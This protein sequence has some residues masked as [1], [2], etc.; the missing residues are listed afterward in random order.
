MSE[1]EQELLEKDV[2]KLI[3]EYNTKVDDEVK[4]KSDEVMKV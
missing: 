2:E 3:K 4:I 1:T